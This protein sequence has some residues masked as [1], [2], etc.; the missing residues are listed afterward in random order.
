MADNLPKLSPT[1]YALL[2]LLAREPRSAYQLTSAMKNSLV[3]VFWPRAESHIYSEPKKLLRHG[4]VREEV[5]VSGGRSRK[6]Y[7]ITAA[8]HDALRHWLQAEDGAELR[9]QSEVMLKLLLANAGPADTARNTLLE[10]LA[11]TE[12]DLQT[13][14]DGIEQVLAGGI[15]ATAGMPW[16]GIAITLMAELLV[17]RLHWNRWALDAIDDEQAAQQ[18]VALGRAAYER[19]LA[20]LNAAREEG[21]ND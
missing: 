6:V 20:L 4:L 5:Q 10:A 21:A 12:R 14:I 8:G 19:A 9:T 2:G 11:G 3:R 13:A 18:P 15:D 16:N 7:S 1:S 17:A